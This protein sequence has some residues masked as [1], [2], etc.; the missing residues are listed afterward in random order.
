MIW[1]FSQSIED[2]GRKIYYGID[3]DYCD[4]NNRCFKNNIGLKIVKRVAF[5]GSGLGKH[6]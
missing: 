2:E 1:S 4:D 5:K 3:R 6:G